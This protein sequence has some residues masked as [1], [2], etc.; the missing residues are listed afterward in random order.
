MMRTLVLI[1]LLFIATA[2]TPD[3]A[4]AAPLQTQGT[5]YIYPDGTIGYYSGQFGRRTSYYYVPPVTTGF[6]GPPVYNATPRGYYTQRP[7]YNGVP[8]LNYP[9]FYYQ[10]NA[11]YWPRP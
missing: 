10:P 7:N 9:G 8:Y 5:T 1:A 4:Q 11:P 2:S 3:F 6:Y